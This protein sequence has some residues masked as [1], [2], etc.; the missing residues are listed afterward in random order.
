MAEMVKELWFLITGL[1]ALVVWLVRLEAGMLQ[2][3]KD[4]QRIEKQ[5]QDDLA[6]TEKHRLK[7]DE[8]LDG[9]R[10]DLRNLAVL[11]QGKQDR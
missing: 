1:I 4:I 7:I 3:R 6:A 10:D 11:I 9:I 8:K 5:R 2:N